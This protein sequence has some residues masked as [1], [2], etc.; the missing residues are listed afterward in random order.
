MNRQPWRFLIVGG[1]IILAMRKD[2]DISEYEKRIDAG[3]AMLYFE[4]V[5]EQTVCPVQWTAGSAENVYGIPEDYEIVAS[6]EV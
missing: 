3:I 6:C 4:A 1:K 5:M 2:S